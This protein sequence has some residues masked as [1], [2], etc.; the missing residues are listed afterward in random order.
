MFDALSITFDHYDHSR[1]AAGFSNLKT[2]NAP[3]PCCASCESDGSHYSDQIHLFTSLK[4][5]GYCI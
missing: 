1:A 2:P 4:K 5:P 3:M